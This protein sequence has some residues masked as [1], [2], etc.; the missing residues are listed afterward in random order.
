LNVRSESGSDSR[1]I[2]VLVPFSTATPVYNNYA[3]VL[4]VMQSKLFDSYS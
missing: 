4:H 3:A 1:E 2:T